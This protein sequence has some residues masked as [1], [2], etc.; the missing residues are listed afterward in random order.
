MVKSIALM[1]WRNIL[2][3][4]MVFWTNF[5]GAVF[6]QF[7][8][9]YFLW[10]SIFD[11]S[12][13]QDFKGYDFKNMVFYYLVAPMT[14]KAVA[15]IQ[16]RIMSIDIYEGGLNKY[17]LYPVSFFKFKLINQF[18]HTS[19]YISQ[20]VVGVFIYHILVGVPENIEFDLLN[21]SFALVTIYLG[22]YLFFMLECAI[23]QL[24]FWVDNVWSLSVL[25]RY[26]VFL[27]GGGLVPTVLFPE[28]A[29]V[30][31]KFTPFSSL[32][33]LPLNIILNKYSFDNVVHELSSLI[34]WSL[35][36][37]LLNKIIWKKGTKVYSG[38]GI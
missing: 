18:V 12:K 14:F 26:I 33:N 10:K 21:I 29:E 31:V 2:A 22:S 38:V 3:Y 25:L 8:I 5:L 7:L 23:E 32:L 24:A 1:E 20:L 13:I 30:F 34:I 16:M 28:W 19:F 6:A 9:G 17:L 37:T 4:R 27:F 36:L 15:G 11:Y 35:L